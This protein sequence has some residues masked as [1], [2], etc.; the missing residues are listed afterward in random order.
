MKNSRPQPVESEKQ[1]N[2]LLKGIMLCR[3]QQEMF[4]ELAYN[5]FMDRK[6]VQD[7]Q[8]LDL[9]PAYVKQVVAPTKSSIRVGLEV[10]RA[11][12]LSA[13]QH[14]PGNKQN[15]RSYN[16]PESVPGL[17]SLQKIAHIGFLLDGI[18]GVG[19]THTLLSCLNTIPRYVMRRNFPGL[20]EICQINYLLID[21]SAVPSLHAFAEEG[22]MQIDA[23]S[24]GNGALFD[25]TMRGANRAQ[26]KLARLRR[27]MK[28]H[29]VSLL[30]LDEVHA[31]NFAQGGADPLLY[32]LLLISNMGIAVIPSG[33][34]LAFQLRESKQSKSKN[35]VSRDAKIVAQILRRLFATNEI[36]L[37]PFSSPKD[38]DFQILSKTF[39]R[40]HL[41]GACDEWNENL[42]VLK[43]NLTGGIQDCYVELH[44][45]LERLRNQD[46]RRSV[47]EAMIR[48]AAGMSTKLKKMS[49]L[50][51]AFREKDL[52]QLRQFKDVDHDY[53]HAKWKI[54]SASDSNDKSDTSDPEDTG[55]SGECKKNGAT[56][57]STN[58]ATEFVNP[59]LQKY[60]EGKKKQSERRIEKQKAENS[61]EAQRKI[62]SVKQ[63]HLDQL[64][65]MI[66]E[67]SGGK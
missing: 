20:K 52:L 43:F 16:E 32:E 31:E 4:K 65:K 58:V 28:T 53:Y 27:L 2:Q 30:I 51:S 7:N 56:P 33:N 38:A 63:F 13:H 17:A 37:D 10:H 1:A 59:D 40:V 23:I 67:K 26:A 55:L 9:F 21:M 39:A 57:I 44:I 14:D 46:P 61:P 12:R 36:R 42:E 35:D 49:G 25:A 5:P 45:Q 66:A 15:Q 22:V 41:G 62:D 60:A 47:D 11:L 48:E 24:G 34:P 54:E 3:T 18:T 19:K 64:D 29:F 8:D 50:I 6:W